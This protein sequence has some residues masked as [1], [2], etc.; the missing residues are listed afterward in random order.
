MPLRRQYLKRGKAETTWQREKGC[1]CRRQKEV[2]RRKGGEEDGEAAPRFTM[3][4]EARVVLC[5]GSCWH[6]TLGVSPVLPPGV[7]RFLNSLP[8]RLLRSLD[9]FANLFS[10]HIH[11]T[12]AP[13]RQ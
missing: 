1:S 11:L 12:L 10:G 6:L 3:A 4:I 5:S 8:G 9:P 13:L 7:S 2:E